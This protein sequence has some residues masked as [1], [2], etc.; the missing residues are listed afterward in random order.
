FFAAVGARAERGR[1][2]TERESGPASPA[3]GVVVSHQFWQE[4]F[5]GSDAALGTAVTLNGL[6]LTFVGVLAAPFGGRSA[7]V[8]GWF[9]ESDVFIPVGHLPPP[10]G[11]AAAGP[12]L[13][14]VGLL[15]PGVTIATASADLAVLSSALE[16]AFPDAQRGRSTS[17]VTLRDTIV[18]DLRPSL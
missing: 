17:L 15:K 10:G 4:R 18:G 16:K 9:F 11:L 7:P 3:P 6:P 13:L 8:G 14:G 2:F 12:S 5:A 1:L